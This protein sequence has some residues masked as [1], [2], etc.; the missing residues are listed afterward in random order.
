[1]HMIGITPGY[2]GGLAERMVLTA[3]TLANGIV[4]PMPDGMSFIEGALAEPCSSVL[5]AHN[6]AGTSVGD[7]VLVIGAGPIGCLHVVVSKARGA[8]VI[9]SQRSEK[10]RE[11]VRLLRPQAVIDPS[12]EDVVTRVR[13]LT[14]GRGADMVI[15]ANGV[16]ATQTLAV[17]CVRKGG[18]VVLF[19][20]LPSTSPMSSFDANRIHYGEIEVVGAFSYHPTLHELALDV[21]SRK[22]VPADLLVTHT[23]PLERAADAFESA[24][25]RVGLKVMVSS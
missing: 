2:P 14:A 6:S 11:L 12:T 8:S 5:A 10:R 3:E 23:F 4:H 24:E 17:E 15:C 22:L 19:G 7:T 21:I 18:Q 1:M 20:G 16:S 13:G 9:V 25:S